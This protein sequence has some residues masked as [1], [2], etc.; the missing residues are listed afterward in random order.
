MFQ[1]FAKFPTLARTIREHSSEAS[2]ANTAY[3]SIGLCAYL[4]FRSFAVWYAVH[5]RWSYWNRWCSQYTS[6]QHAVYF[7]AAHILLVARN[8]L[9][10]VLG[11]HLGVSTIIYYKNV[12]KKSHQCKKENSRKNSCIPLP[13]Q[14]QEASGRSSRQRSTRYRF[15][16]HSQA[17]V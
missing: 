8:L 13:L 11:F 12:D 7:V 5:L 3:L 15:H 4:G 10:S 14:Q 2:S 17:S 16:S 9:F 6:G 1:K